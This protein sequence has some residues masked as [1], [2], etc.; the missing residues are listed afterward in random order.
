M[1]SL[2]QPRWSV[3]RPTISCVKG[4]NIIKT[5]T[6]TITGMSDLGPAAG[7]T[8]QRNRVGRGPGSDRGKTCGRGQKGQKA[9]GKVKSWFE[10]GQTP[11]TKLFPKTGF[12]SQR[13]QPKTINLQ[14]L[15]RL[16]DRKRLDP[17][18]PITMR[19][20]YRSRYFGNMK[21]GVKIL[22]GHPLKFTQTNLHI[23]ATSATERAMQRIE[24]LGGSFTAQYYTPLGLRTLTRPE[25]TLRKYGRIPLRAAPIDRRN[26]EFYR[27]ASRKGYLVDAP[28]APSVKPAF[29]RKPKSTASPLV[30]DL[31]RLRQNDPTAS[32]VQGFR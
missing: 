9:R 16:V 8:R 10:G 5:S 2:I 20:L 27:D 7:A 15:Q 3:F 1:W 18:K 26:I 28:N 11:I 31:E 21:T 32:V 22:A 25:A 19:E 17:S 24:E 23:S 13:P 29:Q 30:A 12:T 6:R 14:D 4:A